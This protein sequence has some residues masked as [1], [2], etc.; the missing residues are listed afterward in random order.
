MVSTAL[1]V[2]R[3]PK[4]PAGSIAETIGDV[5]PEPNWHCEYFML[6]A[7]TLYVLHSY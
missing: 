7:S 5:N 2:F 4:S 3:G 6:T 1:V